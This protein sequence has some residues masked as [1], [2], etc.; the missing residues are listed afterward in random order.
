M[1]KQI[2]QYTIDM[3]QVDRSLKD[4]DQMSKLLKKSLKEIGQEFQTLSK[5]NVD[6]SGKLEQYADN[7]EKKGVKSLKEFRTEQR[8]QNFIVRQGT[9]ALTNMVFALGFLT[10]GNEKADATYKRIT[11]TLMVGV[12]AMNAMEFSLFAVGR[13]GA[14]VGGALGSF[15]M[16]LSALAGPIGIIVAIGAAILSFFQQSN[17]ESAKAAEEGLKKY[18]DE[19]ERIERATASQT[20]AD[21][22]R[23][24]REEKVLLAEIED[25]KNKAAAGDGKAAFRL[26]LLKGDLIDLQKQ[27]AFTGDML[28]IKLGKEVKSPKGTSTGTSTGKSESEQEEER[29]RRAFDLQRL[30]F[31]TGNQTEAGYL[32]NLETFKG[33]AQTAEL[34]LAIEKQIQDTQSKAADNQKKSQEEILRQQ[35][36]QLDELLAGFS[37]IQQGLN[38]IGIGMDST[39][40]KMIQAAQLIAQM[41][42]ISSKIGTQKEGAS[43]GDIFSIIGSVLSIAG[44]FAG[45]PGHDKG[46]YTGPGPRGKVAGVVHAGEI[47]FEKP[48]V[49]RFGPEL[50][51]TRNR[52]QALKMQ[53]YAGGGMVGGE[54]AM[55]SMGGS[56]GIGKALNNL[57]RAIE[58]M[59][60]EIKVTQAGKDM[61]GAWRLADEAFNKLKN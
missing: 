23:L 6:A 46:G 48:L 25:L 36:Q 41:A 42:A 5:T 24:H 60:A 51:Q 38:A 4:V 54:R 45:V 32:E 56:A 50:M 29:I 12:G 47:V 10:A 31:E 33:L 40:S 9:Q 1:G 43:T 7:L 3:S 19:L 52:L 11:N 53:G 17:A 55:P 30:L 13:A 44:L 14:A 26:K 49:D 37:A 57:A 39:I 34:R 28:I 35:R 20:L 15:S 22:N 8:D 27:I 18:G 2:E 16:R 21:Y 61:H 59:P 58:G